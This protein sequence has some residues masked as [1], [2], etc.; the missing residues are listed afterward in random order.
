[1]GG[2][3]W[4]LARVVRG[5]K[6]LAMP[7]F[8][9]AILVRDRKPAL[10]ATFVLCAASAIGVVALLSHNELLFGGPFEFGYPVTAEGAKRLNAFDT[11]VGKG[12]YGFLLSPG[13]S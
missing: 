6:V 4:G 9:V 7:V 5:W 10:R 13:K 11:P 12:L 3:S 1:M 8:A 2:V